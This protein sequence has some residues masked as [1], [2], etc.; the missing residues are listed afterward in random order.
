MRIPTN[1]SAVEN[2]T[3]AM[4]LHNLGLMPKLIGDNIP[5]T[6]ALVRGF[7]STAP[8]LSFS[9]GYSKVWVKSNKGFKLSNILFKI[10]GI[11]SG[12]TG[13]KNGMCMEHIDTDWEVAYVQ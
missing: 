9:R 13:L 1:L 10:Y 3:I 2:Y 8:H 11:V 12:D 5:G 4:R 7:I 6:K